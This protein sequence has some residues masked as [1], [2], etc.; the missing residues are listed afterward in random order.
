MGCGDLFYLQ[1]D[2]F[3]VGFIGISLLELCVIFY[4]FCKHRK[5]QNTENEDKQPLQDPKTEAD[6]NGHPKVFP[7]PDGRKAE[8]GGVFSKGTGQEGDSNPSAK[9][10]GPKAEQRAKFSKGAGNGTAKLQMK[11][12]RQ[13]ADEPFVNLG[14][15]DKQNGNSAGLPPNNERNVQVKRSVGKTVAEQPAANV[16]KAPVSPTGDEQSPLLQ[17][18]GSS[19]VALFEGTTHEEPLKQLEEPRSG[20]SIT[21]PKSVGNEHESTVRHEVESTEFQK[22]FRKS[23]VDKLIDHSCT[24]NNVNERLL[25]DRTGWFKQLFLIINTVLSMLLSEE[26]VSPYLIF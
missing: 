6:Q 15:G 21:S 9:P 20:D 10:G 12:H 25:C 16:G 11:E 14:A 5:S 19:D 7:K 17:D 18:E 3:A 23:E 24:S 22:Y 2:C 8:Q 26:A 4:L 13:Q 1:V